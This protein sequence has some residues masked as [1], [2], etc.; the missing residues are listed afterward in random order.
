MDD[1]MYEV[2]SEKIKECCTSFYENDMIRRFLGESFHPGGEELT[3]HLGEVLGLDEDSVVLDVACGRGTSS[4]ALQEEFGC[5]IV[6]IDMS[7]KNLAHALENSDG[8]SFI[9][10]D[11]E[12]LPIEKGTFDAVICECSLCIFPDKEEA[13]DEIYRVLKVGGSVGMTD[14]VIDGE[15]PREFQGIL[16]HAACVSGALRAEGYLDLLEKRGFRDV[17]HEDHAHTLDELIDKAERLIKV[18]DLIDECS[19]GVDEIF[20]LTAGD[21]GKMIEK[22]RKLVQEG[23]IGYGLFSGT[24]EEG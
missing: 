14:I 9:R 10:G 19:C 15:L 1:M 18:W 13:L 6:G 16:S 24:K 7:E 12:E 4:L 22:G 23:K 3:L 5:R 11:A 2:G 20:G 17:Y 21:A 8:S